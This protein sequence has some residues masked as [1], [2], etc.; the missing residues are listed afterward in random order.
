MKKNAIK[1]FV[2]IIAAASII[3]CKTTHTSRSV[4]ATGFL[5]D[6]TSLQAGSGDDPQLIYINETANW[7]GYKKVLM[8]QIRVY[9][10]RDT[11]LAKMSAADRQLLVQQIRA[12]RIDILVDLAGHTAGN[13]LLAFAERPAPVQVSHLVG[14]GITTG[15]SAMDYVLTDRWLSPRGSDGD[16]RRLWLPPPVAADGLR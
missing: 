3:G 5:S 1:L 6:Y 14:M 11:K 13:R 16:Y 7:A 2:L 9:T 10:P 8:D 15:M 4:D 12:D